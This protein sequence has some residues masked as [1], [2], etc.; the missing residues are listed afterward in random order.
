M[1][2]ATQFAFR[3]LSVEIPVFAYIW[4]YNREISTKARRPRKP[5]THRERCQ[6]API[7]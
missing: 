7:L 1:A 6:I 5:G 3:A 4:R 2:R